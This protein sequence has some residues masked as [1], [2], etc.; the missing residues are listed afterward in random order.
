MIVLPGGALSDKATDF[1]VV[2]IQS[3]LRFREGCMYQI[4]R[5]GL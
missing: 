1:G 2:Q 4:R 3:F 5:D